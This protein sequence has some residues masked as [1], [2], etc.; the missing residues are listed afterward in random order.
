MPCKKDWLDMFHENMDG[1]HIYLRDD[2][3]HEIR[4]YGDIY[5]NFPN[6]K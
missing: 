1:A 6:S 5:V 2:R 3:S 4:G